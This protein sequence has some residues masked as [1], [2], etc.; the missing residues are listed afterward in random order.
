MCVHVFVCLDRSVF[1][2]NRRKVNVY[3]LHKVW[4]DI[5]IVGHEYFYAKLIH[6]ISHEPGAK[7][8]SL[9]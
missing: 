5:N 9:G 3:M 4:G 7:L 1:F 8:V 6:S 2:C